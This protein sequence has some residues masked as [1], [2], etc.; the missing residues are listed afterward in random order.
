M[1]PTTGRIS[2]GTRVS[3]DVTGMPATANV[4][5]LRLRMNADGWVQMPVEQSFVKSNDTMQVVFS[6]QVLPLTCA[7]TH[8]VVLVELKSRC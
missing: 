1:E 5:E 2:G 8:P 6:T 4:K 7:I 3:V